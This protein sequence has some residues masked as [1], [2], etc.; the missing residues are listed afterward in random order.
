MRAAFNE[1]SGLAP[2]RLEA[3]SER[4]V[5]DGAHEVVVGEGRK[6]VGQ[7]QVGA[8]RVGGAVAVLAAT[9]DGIVERWAEAAQQVGRLVIALEVV[10]EDEQEPAVGGG[11]RAVDLPSG[12][13]DV[14]E[15]ELLGQ[16]RHFAHELGVGFGGHE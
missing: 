13:S 12:L 10:R 14:V 16:R 8:S 1:F 5:A 9:D 4:H 7:P 11:G 3:R 2:A 15:H 6:S